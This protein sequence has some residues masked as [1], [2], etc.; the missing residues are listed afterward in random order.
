MTVEERFW[1]KVDK[2]GECWEWTAGRLYRRDGTPSYGSFNFNGNQ[3]V[4]H[5]VSWQLEKGPIPP[6]LW[7]LHHCDNVSCVRPSHLYLGTHA[8][9]TRDAV[10]R[11]RMAFG[12]RT[13]NHKLR[14]VDVRAIRAVAECGFTTETIGTFFGVSGSTVRYIL[15]GEHWRDV[16]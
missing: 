11:R 7:V 15:R 3:Q 13:W 14:E 16:A 4:A 10:V 1:A 2:A 12:E 5:R 8:E 9:N 6:G